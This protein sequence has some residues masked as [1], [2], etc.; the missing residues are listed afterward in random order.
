[1]L[2]GLYAMPLMRRVTPPLIILVLLLSACTG[3]GGGDCSQQY[4]D[5]TIG[6][7]LPDGWTVMDRETL[8]RRGAPSEMVAGFQKEAAVAGQFPTLTVTREAVATG[9][10]S[11]AYSKASIRSVAQLPGYKLLDERDLRIDGK[12]VGLHIFSAKPLPEEPE[13]RFYQVS[14]AT[15]EVGYSFTALTPLAVNDSLARQIVT[16][17]H[18]ITLTEPE[19]AK[20]E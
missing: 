17:M 3:G 4:W 10:D 20:Q 5:G 1:M 19:A 2:H 15:K 11:T 18:S 7:C 9:I 14:V 6:L 8:N 12:P 13:R 16:M